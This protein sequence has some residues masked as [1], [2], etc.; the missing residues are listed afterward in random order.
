[1]IWLSDKDS[2]GIVSRSVNKS[3]ADICCLSVILCVTLVESSILVLQDELVIPVVLDK[4]WHIVVLGT[5]ET[6]TLNPTSSLSKDLSVMRFQ[7]ISCLVKRLRIAFT[8]TS[9][10]IHVQL[11]SFSSFV[12]L[13]SFSSLVSVKYGTSTV[14]TVITQC[15]RP[16]TLDM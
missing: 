1:M 4:S 3:V 7:Y 16:S 13:F 12:V 11:L 9:F 6:N 5:S 8:H 10:P 14:P 15:Q 2:L